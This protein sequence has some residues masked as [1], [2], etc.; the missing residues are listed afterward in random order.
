MTR[1]PGGFA[2]TDLTPLRE[3]GLDDRAIHDA[4]QIV[5]YF[6]YINRVAD[7]LGVDP[8]HWLGSLPGD[9]TP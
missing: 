9:P 2:E 4:V 5:A 1:D 8:E 7:G 3:A 6:S